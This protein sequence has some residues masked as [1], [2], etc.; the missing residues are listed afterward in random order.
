M[1]KEKWEGRLMI[2]IAIVYQKETKLL[3]NI[4][5][6]IR[7]E[8]WQSDSIS[9]VYEYS[10]IEAFCKANK[11]SLMDIVFL[12]DTMDNCGLKAAKYIRKTGQET[13]LYFFGSF[14]N[15]AFYGYEYKAV[16]Y[17]TEKE[18]VESLNIYEH[19]FRD[20]F[21]KKTIFLFDQ[22]M[23]SVWAMCLSEVVYI[24][25]RTG[26][27]YT[28]RG[29]Q[30]SGYILPEK[31][32]ETIQK[33]PSFLKVSGEYLINGDFLIDVTRQMICLYQNRNVL[34]EEKDMDMLKEFLR[35]MG[36]KEFLSGT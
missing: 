16:H 17:L 12:E 5:E 33:K 29:E 13:S 36:Q 1:L 25:L 32:L 20:H 15:R 2:K 23:D 4:R 26:D 30:K 3:T 9:V 35:I 19:F 34:C 24:D 7:K 28:E 21:P 18:Q 31:A 6:K 10:T 11:R 22:D 14:I 27:I 8:A